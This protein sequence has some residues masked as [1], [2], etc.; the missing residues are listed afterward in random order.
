MREK[1]GEK[2]VVFLDCF[3]PI[4]RLQEVE[5]F[6]CSKDALSQEPKDVFEFLG[7][8]LDAAGKRLQESYDKVYINADH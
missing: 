3:A 7:Q 5:Q 2:K 4:R 6:A 1:W 8:Q